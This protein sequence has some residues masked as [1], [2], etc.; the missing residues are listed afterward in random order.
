MNL[1]HYEIDSTED[2]NTYVFVS[3]GRNVNI[4][5]V[6]QFAYTSSV[7]SA[8]RYNVALGDW[9][10]GKIEDNSITNNGD[11]K[12]VMATMAELLCITHIIFLKE[13]FLQQVVHGT[14]AGYIKCLYQTILLRSG[15]ILQYLVSDMLTR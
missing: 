12:M 5:K 6:V 15:R 14:E 4:F 11:V 13:R 9:T 1:Q 3:T 10:D 8:N 7:V 2:L